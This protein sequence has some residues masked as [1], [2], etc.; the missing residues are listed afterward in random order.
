M[1]LLGSSALRKYLFGEY[2]DDPTTNGGYAYKTSMDHLALQGPVVQRPHSI[3]PYISMHVPAVL[4]F[5]TAGTCMFRRTRS[6]EKWMLCNLT[7]AVAFYVSMKCHKVG[8]GYFGHQSAFWGCFAGAGISLVRAVIG[9]G[10]PRTNLMSCAAFT[11]MA[12]FEIGRFHVW[13]AH[14][15]TLQKV[16]KG[17]SVSVA[18]IWQPYIPQDIDPELIMFRGVEVAGEGEESGGEVKQEV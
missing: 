2:G 18:S 16:N 9:S 17:Q 11:C 3:K 7:L 5:A 1:G 12:W 6:Q 13:G 15:M 14:I 10:N 4:M 8:N